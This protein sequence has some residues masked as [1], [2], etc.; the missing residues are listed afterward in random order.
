MVFFFVDVVVVCF[1]VVVAV[2]YVGFVTEHTTSAWECSP[3]IG[4]SETVWPHSDI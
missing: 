1:A 2:L 4:L 3:S